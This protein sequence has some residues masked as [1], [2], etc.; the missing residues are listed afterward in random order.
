MSSALASA[1]VQVSDDFFVEF[2]ERPYFVGDG[3]R[4]RAVVSVR[5]LGSTPL[6][7]SGPG[8][9]RLAFYPT[10]DPEGADAPTDL[11][12]I[13]VPI[14]VPGYEAR[15]FT[16]ETAPPEG[17]EPRLHVFAS[18]IGEAGAPVAGDGSARHTLVR[19]DPMHERSWNNQEAGQVVYGRI[20]ELNQKR[21]E[22]FLGAGNRKRPLF[23]HLETVNICNLKCVI[24]PYDQMARAKETMSSELFRKIISDYVEMGGGDVALTPSVGD[25]LLDKKLVER[26]EYLRSVP[27]IKDI[28]FVTNA[29]NAGVF[30][31]EDLRKIVGACRRINI[32]IY[33]L[34]EE[35]TAAMTR[36]KGRYNTILAQAKRMVAAAGP[37]T[38]IVFAFRLLK[39]RARERADEWMIEHFGR[40]FPNGLLTEFGNWAGAVDATVPLP[41]EGKW[42]DT[43][44]G[45]NGDGACAYPILH[46]K[47]AVN[48]DVK[49]CS[50]IDYD[51][52][53]ENIIGNATAA[54]LS[55]IYNGE[56]ARNLWQRGL[57]ICAGCTHAIPMGKLLGLYDYLD[58]P[59]NKLGV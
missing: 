19:H 14:M 51:S 13:A 42:S 45:G 21:L 33:G 59:I 53:P 17:D 30:P 37:D 27:E 34:D 10:I 40:I 31:D 29:G 52:N 58:E 56:A 35:E 28:G 8:A 1:P 22:P 32:S 46:L 7:G 47:V 38:T 25:V 57:S 49:F 11:L 12:G 48:G 16:I 54:S 36:R 18:L 23:L 44:V 24:C 5:N 3:S 2:S 50:C 43:S 41:F 39:E 15:E 55:D 26:I 20:P 6:S 4:I 9:L